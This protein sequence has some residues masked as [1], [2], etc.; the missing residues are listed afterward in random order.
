MSE[1]VVILKGGTK[2][3]NVRG[4]VLADKAN[5]PFTKRRDGYRLRWWGA[6]HPA[7]KKIRDLVEIEE[8]GD[9]LC[10]A[11]SSCFPKRLKVSKHAMPRH[12]C[13]FEE[14]H[15]L[16]QCHEN[17]NGHERVL[18]RGDVEARCAGAAFCGD[19]SCHHAEIHRWDPLAGCHAIKCRKL[20]AILENWDT[21]MRGEKPD[22]IV[23]CELRL[24]EAT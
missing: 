18:D 8:H 14:H 5:P 3:K 16:W 19:A 2:Q 10:P 21:N 20:T 1:L 22:D 17:G 24:R 23:V 4:A 12:R 15:A 9:G 7:S 13:A 6:D 11:R